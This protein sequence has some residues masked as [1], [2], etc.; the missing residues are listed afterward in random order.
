MQIQINF[1]DIETSQALADHVTTSVESAL[2]RFSDRVTRVE[3]H[4]RDDKQKRSGPDDHRC[5]MEA[6]PAGDKPLAVDARGEDIYAAVRETADKLGR[7]V[8][9]HFER[10]T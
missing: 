5:L 9:R 7:A 8:T 3:I 2:G 4:L 6:R 1:G 10:R